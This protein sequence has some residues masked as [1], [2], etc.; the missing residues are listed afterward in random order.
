MPKHSEEKQCYYSKIVQE[1]KKKSKNVVK[2]KLVNLRL[3]YNCT[4]LTTL[5]W[6]EKFPIQ[7]LVI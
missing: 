2:C 5:L 1:H 6:V 4:I 7:S 3:I